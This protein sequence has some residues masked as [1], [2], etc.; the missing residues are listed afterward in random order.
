LLSA[1]GEIDELIAEI[2][3]SNGIAEIAQFEIEEAPIERQGGIDIL[4]F[5]RHTV[6]TNRF[7][8]SFGHSV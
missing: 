7:R 2:D 1:S 6:N 8:L 3:E 4:Y 5:Q